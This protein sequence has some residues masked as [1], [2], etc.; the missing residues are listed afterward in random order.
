[1]ACDKSA[2]RKGHTRITR[3]NPGLG[4]PQGVRG[5]ALSDLR[6]DGCSMAGGYPFATCVCRRCYL[7]ALKFHYFSVPGLTGPVAELKCTTIAPSG[8]PGRGVAS[9]LWIDGRQLRA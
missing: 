4:M 6:H 9:S 5:D 7:T 1:V 2:L 8:A 3:H